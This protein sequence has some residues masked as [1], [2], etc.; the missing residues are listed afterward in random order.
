MAAYRQVYGVIHFTSPAGWLPVHRDER[1]A[2][3]LVTST[4][5]LC[6]LKKHLHIVSQWELKRKFSLTSSNE[7]M[8]AK[9]LKW[10][11]LRDVD[12][13]TPSA[14]SHYWLPIKITKKLPMTHWPSKTVVSN[15]S[16]PHAPYFIMCQN[17]IPLSILYDS[18][19]TLRITW[20]AIK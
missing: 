9:W 13:V 14:T 6:L 18:K 16:L 1:R 17:V 8:A 10:H 5:Q 2:Q 11:R 15:L 3:H 20:D 12:S 4:G 19:D 7:Q